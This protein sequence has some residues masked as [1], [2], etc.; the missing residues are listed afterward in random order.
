MNDFFFFLLPWPIDMC[1]IF[2]KSITLFIVSIGTAEEY[3]ATDI[4]H[5]GFSYDLCDFY[6]FFT[7]GI[8]FN[9]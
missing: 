5:M 8:L 9:S 7:F 3:P 2:A 6:I 4:Y 1:S